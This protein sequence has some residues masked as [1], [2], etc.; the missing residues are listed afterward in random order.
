MEYFCVTSD[1]IDVLILWWS[2]YFEVR[3]TLLEDAK[4]VFPKGRMVW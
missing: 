3:I 2:T 4:Y 1:V